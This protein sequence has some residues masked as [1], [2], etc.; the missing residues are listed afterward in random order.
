[1]IENIKQRLYSLGVDV[2]EDDNDN[3]E[4]CLEK[5]IKHVKNGCSI[6]VI[7]KMLEQ[8][9][10]D[11]VCGEFLKIKRKSF[12]S[13]DISK[14]LKSITEGDTRIEYYETQ[15]DEQKM[16]TLIEH[17]LNFGKGDLINYRCI[18]W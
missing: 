8:V 7:P 14:I 13:G 5:V 17:L 2:T 4:F 12:K 9:V 10:I 16:D 15:N 6:A 3:I 11:M 18:R 1:M